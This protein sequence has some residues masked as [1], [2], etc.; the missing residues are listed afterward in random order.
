MSRCLPFRLHLVALLALG[1]VPSAA[2]A[3]SQ[4]T[5]SV[6]EAARRAKQQKKA[7]K[8]PARVITE[9]DVKIDP[10]GTPENPVE[11]ANAPAAA[12]ADAP[13]PASKG[14]S[15]DKQGDKKEPK[16]VTELKEQIKQAERDLDL[17]QRRLSLDQEVL[18]GKT[19]YSSDKE[20]L[21]QIEN[22]KQHIAQKQQE[23]QGLKSKLADLLKSLSLADASAPPKS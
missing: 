11:D 16:E 18:Y 15:K 2:L 8:K 23:L 20:G 14:G 13:D 12:K 3:Q 1:F 7:P 17:Q 19:N 10:P 21:A 22:E 6:A 5:P 4:D 9:E